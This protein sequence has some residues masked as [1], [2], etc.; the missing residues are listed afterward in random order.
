ME[1]TVTIHAT[2]FDYIWRCLIHCVN[3]LTN[4][5]GIDILGDETSWARASYDESGDGL[6]GLIDN[7]TGLK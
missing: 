1:R 6:A 4:N 3:F 7:N 5:A 2:K